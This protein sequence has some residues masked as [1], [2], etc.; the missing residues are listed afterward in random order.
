MI[1]PT[2]II[3]PKAKIG[4]GCEIGP[5]CIVGENVTLGEKNKLH[6]HVVVDGHTDIGNENE[7]FPFTSIGLKSQDLKWKGG[8][9]HVRIGDKNVFREGVTV[10]S[11]T[12]DG[13]ATVIGNG[14]LFLIH[15]HIA[16]DCQL[17]NGIIMSGFVGLAGHVVVEDFATFGGYTAVHQFCRIGTRCMTGGLTRLPQDVAPY[18]IVEGNPAAARA[19]NKVG[20]E[21]AGFSTE[22]QSALRSAYK[23]IFRENLPTADALKKVE[24]ELP[25]LPE[26]KHLVQF[27]RASERGVCK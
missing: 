26:V 16:H 10:H 3:H 27:I 20:L 9:T 11:A 23:I 5:Y 21:R 24:A 6:S 2:A 1:H 13:D 7:F 4:N 14:N 19:V 8:I 17:G 12:S 25:P 18:T 22:T 15:V